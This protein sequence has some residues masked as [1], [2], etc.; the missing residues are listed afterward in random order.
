[1]KISMEWSQEGDRI[2][3]MLALRGITVERAHLLRKQARLP[4]DEQ[5]EANAAALRKADVGAWEAADKV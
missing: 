2:Y 5:I 1:M 3:R 4:R